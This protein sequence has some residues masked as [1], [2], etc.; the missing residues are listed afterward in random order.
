ML[1]VSR[2][3]K[4]T[5]TKNIEQTLSWTGSV[6]AGAGAATAANLAKA[7]TPGKPM[8]EP[9]VEKEKWSVWMDIP[10]ELKT[11]LE[12][13]MEK[14]GLDCLQKNAQIVLD[15]YQ[16]M[17]LKHVLTL[18]IKDRNL[19]RLIRGNR[20]IEDQSDSP[21]DI[22]LL[23][24][25]VAKSS[26][27]GQDPWGDKALPEKSSKE[28]DEEG[29]DDTSSSDYSGV[30]ALL[31]SVQ[32]NT[33]NYLTVHL[34]RILHEDIL[35][36]IVDE[37]MK[38][39]ADTDKI[40][41]KTARKRM[42]WSVYR[43][44]VLELL[45]EGTG[46]YE[47]MTLMALCRENGESA[48]RWIQRFGIGKKHVEEKNIK[49]PEELI[50]DLATRYLADK[51]KV[52]MGTKL[53]SADGKKK[54]TPAQAQSAINKHSWEELGQ[55]I[56]ISLQPGD[57]KYR[58]SMHKH[59][60]DTR[61]FTL[62]QAKEYLRLYSPRVLA[63]SAD[64][65]P[66]STRKSRMQPT[67]R[68]CTEAGLTGKVTRHRTEACVDEVREMNLKKLKA[69]RGRK[70]GRENTANFSGQRAQK[71]SKFQK[72]KKGKNSD[73]ECKTCKD[74]GRPFRH[75]QKTCN[76]APGGPWH[77]KSGEE[78]R[79][80]QKKF[81]EARKR[82]RGER[83][84][85]NSA[86]QE[87][88][89]RKRSKLVEEATNK[90]LDKPLW[91]KSCTML[92]E[93]EAQPEESGPSIRCNQGLPTDKIGSARAGWSE[94]HPGVKCNSAPGETVTRRRGSD[95]YPGVD[96]SAT[97]D[98]TDESI[99]SDSW[100][101]RVK[102]FFAD[103]KFREADKS[104]FPAEHT[105][106]NPKTAIVPWTGR[107]ESLAEKEKIFIY[108]KPLR[109]PFRFRPI[110]DENLRCKVCRQPEV[111]K[112]SWRE[113]W[114]WHGEGYE[115]INACKAKFHSPDR[116]KDFVASL[117]SVQAPMGDAENPIDL[118]GQPIEKDIHETSEEQCYMMSDADGE[119]VVSDSEY[120]EE[121][122]LPDDDCIY[123]TVAPCGPDGVAYPDCHHTYYWYMDQP[124][125]MFMNCLRVDYPIWGPYFKLILSGG[126]VVGY[127]MR[128][129]TLKFNK[130]KHVHARLIMK[131]LPNAR[132]GYSFSKCREGAMDPEQ[133]VAK[134]DIQAAAVAAAAD[135]LAEAARQKQ[136]VDPAIVRAAEDATKVI[137]LE[138]W[139]G[140]RQCVSVRWGKSQPFRR[141]LGALAVIWVKPECHLVLLT[142][143]HIIA[144]EGCVR[145]TDTPNSLALP[146]GGTLTMHYLPYR[147][148]TSPAFLPTQTVAW[149]IL[150]T[151]G[152][153]VWDKN[154]SQ[155]RFDRRVRARG[156]RWGD[157]C[158]NEDYKKNNQ[159]Y[160][161][162]KET[163][164]LLSSVIQN[165]YTKIKLGR[166][167][168]LLPKRLVGSSTAY[169]PEEES[170]ASSHQKKRI[171]KIVKVRRNFKRSKQEKSCIDMKIV[172]TSTED[173]GE[174]ST[175][176]RFNPYVDREPEM[177]SRYEN[178]NREISPCITGKM[179]KNTRNVSNSYKT[180]SY[181]SKSI[182]NYTDRKNPDFLTKTSKNS[183]G[184]RP[185][186]DISLLL[187]S[188]SS[189]SSTLK[190]ED[191]E[192]TTNMSGSSD[193][194]TTSEIIY[195]FP[196]DYK[197]EAKACPEK[198]TSDKS[199]N[200]PD[201]ELPLAQ[202]TCPQ[203]IFEESPP[204][205]RMRA[206]SRNITCKGSHN[207]LDTPRASEHEKM[208]EEE[209]GENSPSEEIS[210]EDDESNVSYVTKGGPHKRKRSGSISG[211]TKQVKIRYSETERYRL[212]RTYIRIIDRNGIT[213]RVQAALDTQSNVSYAKMHLGT[214]RS[215]RSYE[216]RRVKGIGGYTQGSIPLTTRI[217]K[218]GQIINIDTR[219]PPPHMFTEQDGP[220]VL[221]SAQHCVLLQI[222]MNKA[223][224]S[225]KHG[226]TPYLK[227]RRPPVDSRYTS[228]ECCIAEKLME[229][230]LEKTGGSDKEPKQCSIDDVVTAEDFS[231]EQIRLVKSICQKYR[232]VFASNPDEIPP[233]LKD[234]KPHVFKMKEG[235]KPI[236]CKRPNWGP[237]QRRYLEQWTR[238]AIEQGLMEPA[239][240]SEWASRPV[241]VGKYRGNTSKKDVPDGIRTC[242]DFT[243]VNEFIVKQPPQYTDPF[244]EIRRA[245][246][247]TYYFEAD[248][249]K[250]F[251]S[252]PLAEESRDI[253]TTWTPLG[254]MRWLR[255]I[256]G[257]KDASGRA[258]MEYTAAMTRYLSAEDRAHLAN[259]QDDFVGFHN[260][261]PGLIRAF[262]AFLRMCD[263]AGITL[264]PAKIR[265]GIRKCKF[266]GFNLSK[267]GME[268]S[269]K[270]LDPVQKMTVPKNRSE[271]RSVLGVFNQFRHFFVRYDRLVLHIQK[272]LRKN[273]PFV[274]S[275][276]AQKGYDTVRE[277]LLSGEL[278][279]ASP[280][281]SLPLVLETDGSDD[282]WGAILLQVDQGKR[283]VIKM[284]SKQWKTLHMRRAPPY[285][286]ETK[287]WMNGL[288]N[289]R[290][291]ADYSPF[292]VQCITDHIPL[293]YVKNT[294]GKGPVS[295]FILDN[296]SSLDYTITYRPGGKLVEADS[297]SRFPCIGPKTLA[298]D[299][300]IESYNILLDSLPQN[301]TSEGKVW[302]YAQSETDIIQQ[303]VRRW[304]ATLPKCVPARKVPITDS[305]TADKI[306]NID[307]SLGLWV[308]EA[309]KVKM[310]V[311]KALSKGKPFACLVPSC[312]VHLIPEGPEHQRIIIKAVKIVFLQPEMTWII[313]KIKSIIHHQVYAV[314]NSDPTE[315]TFGDL[316]DFR[317]IVRG[318]PDWD[319]KKWVPLQAK[320]ITSNPKIYTKDKIST[321]QSD[322]F[323][324]YTPN[325]DNTFAIVP[326]VYRKE[327]VEW[328]HQQL[329]HGGHAKVYNA[330]N[331][332]WHWPDMKKTVRLIVTACAACQLL[333]A[334][335]A[336]AHRHF[337]AKVF[338]T[339]RT[340]WGMDFYGVAESKNGY[341][342][343]LG[344]IDL[345]TA[346]TRLFAC[347]RRTAPVVT[348]CTLHGIVLRDGCPL[349]IHSDA[350]REFIS[351]AMKRLCQLI[352][353]QQTTTLAH[354]PTGNATIE[355]LWQWIASCLRIM[356]MEQY[357]EWEKYVRLM[358]HTWNTSYHSVLQCSPFEAAHGL[359]ARSAIDS[360]TRA[361]GRVETDIMTADGIEAMRV[362]AR[363]FEQQIHNVRKEAAAAN[364]T[365]LRK[366]P[367]KSYQIGDE[368]S[369]YLPPSEKDALAMGRKPKHLLQ[370]RGP[371]FVVEKLSNTTY[372]I[373]YEGRKYNRC[374]S[375]LRPYKSDK[376]PLD[377]PMANHEEMQERKLIVGNYVALCDSADPEDD[378]F[379]LCKVIAIEDHTAVLLNYATFSTNLAKAKFSIMYQERRGLRYTTDKPRINP[380]SQEVIDRVSLEEADDYIDHYDIKLTLRGRIK[381]RCIKQLKKLG[382]KHH[383]LGKTFP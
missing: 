371:A 296:L 67:C 354:H 299:G 216:S 159:R 304:M 334:K 234:A 275:D 257:T 232:N 51:E 205:T 238:K 184:T 32:D 271:V 10:L 135:Q 357:Q 227:K 126:Q 379:H 8:Y 119:Y 80:L 153:H 86:F 381:M 343:L 188:D 99:T 321:R 7:F 158:K 187:R 372:Q 95:F 22:K 270:N 52:I 353:C 105:V 350:A 358:E 60:S 57:I 43:Q 217:I 70:R 147:P 207:D 331:K 94:T 157:F 125:W 281:N 340:S 113:K 61:L 262:E 171:R 79:A 335:R 132:E 351:K 142:T 197:T 55:L 221:L 103:M 87:M 300:V 16:E 338:C 201:M 63:A 72:S 122:E 269:E 25:Q 71:I 235:C 88:P 164:S 320:M 255:L 224:T 46:L 278:Y 89:L 293:T 121:E 283:Q 168:P 152:V 266:Y 363:A 309:D 267:K 349:H 380:R 324:L 367:N 285:Y 41:T 279:L 290:I 206:K 84:S 348:D 226:E 382:L 44:V 101:L 75:A 151:K 100:Y 143:A 287:A 150:K 352:G 31:K 1:L 289:S 170:A 325:K 337:R 213:R 252:I 108:S 114:E 23:A 20:E 36:R 81:Y 374:F 177:T 90:F 115:C 195:K 155:R 333:K 347:K 58:K 286:K 123:I 245:S 378:H 237:C 92:A 208:S 4:A 230:Y 220:S 54:M 302:V 295:Q 251:N 56:K 138:I 203:I 330:L 260:T 236:Y 280:N 53:T 356:T 264:N 29:E 181:R 21:G 18:Q 301:W 189:T 133:R 12:Q 196:Q 128:P 11:V 183:E 5:K 268:P 305:L 174:L 244:E 3:S 34:R 28:P 26:L 129:E 98:V 261:I 186:R 294:S 364:A 130:G 282:G 231:P 24:G 15:L 69:F 314:D 233:P 191:V 48:A 249:Q 64:Q 136:E 59:L 193:D 256:M 39:A 76:Y 42:P 163:Y 254:L 298:T 116:A 176:S 140:E 37:E 215:W 243:R 106:A 322:G 361:S 241:L 345:A 50:V 45:P 91:Q 297:V 212:L 144:G 362:T 317:G 77:G 202:D 277:K 328:Q 47:L 165:Q 68:K 247:H 83:S 326:K 172:R 376:L 336:R 9:G 223:L 134:D 175:S 14:I 377:L 248:G 274:W 359:K 182:E 291:Y 313:H 111:A 97:L 209:V 117:A 292:P 179:G 341:N 306:E 30:Q 288:E 373:E 49:L 124:M 327:L 265:I 38:Y 329:C 109:T 199:I 40:R 139:S 154:Q 62:D 342:N 82:T 169:R 166:K 344:A 228:Q 66:S 93:A 253:T 250:Q 310:V 307:Y 259:F 178:I 173:T 6:R 339:P 263:K 319:F 167:K 127:K 222:D 272:L 318:T 192:K 323:K 242:V 355:R 198:S 131:H 74:S 104:S 27:L 180:S 219:S 375:E 102:S 85:T 315:L 229:R 346:E 332:H 160:S 156:S 258:Q 369:F 311:N 107:E 239:P 185:R 78:L 110:L 303:E 273:E 65:R 35:L 368:V 383:V 210:S 161:L 312:L 17:I 2:M 194:T 365:L 218:G 240:E 162:Y 145:A 366:G 284:W 204:V 149:N 370:Y 13:K 316:N 214:P 360:L 211:T 225:L 118:T 308:P 141:L 73:E 200:Y 137:V 276:Q 120:E 96:S 148:A 19:G 146:R 33:W 190:S 112:M 246:G